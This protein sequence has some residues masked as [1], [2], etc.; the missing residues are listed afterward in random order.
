MK[1]SYLE[2]LFFIILGQTLIFS[3]IHQVPKNGFHIVL[4][5]LISVIECIAWG[6]EI[7]L[8]R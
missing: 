6:R 5:L 8:K 3:G 1:R 2:H 4:G 7:F